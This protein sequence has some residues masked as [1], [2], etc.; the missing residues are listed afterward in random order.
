MLYVFKWSV[1]CSHSSTPLCFVSEIMVSVLL[2]AH[3]TQEM[4]EW[5]RWEISRERQERN[6]SWETLSL[7]CLFWQDPPSVRGQFPCLTYWIRKLDLSTSRDPSIHPHK[8]LA[9]LTFWGPGRG[10]QTFLPFVRNSTWALSSCPFSVKL[11]TSPAK[12]LKG[13]SNPPLQFFYP[14]LPKNR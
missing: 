13:L 2:L 9:F 14:P 8:Y 1:M 12:L 11:W 7:M 5:E 4:P 3:T 10:K 6:T